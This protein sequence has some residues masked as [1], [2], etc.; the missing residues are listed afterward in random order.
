MRAAPDC[1]PPLTVRH[2]SQPRSSTTPPPQQQDTVHRELLPCTGKG[3]IAGAGQLRIATR[4]AA[5]R[6]RAPPQPKASSSGAHQGLVGIL[7]LWY[8]N[9]VCCTLPCVAETLTARDS[10]AVFDQANVR[11]QHPHQSPRVS[12]SPPRYCPNQQPDHIRFEI[13]TASLCGQIKAPAR[14]CHDI[15]SAAPLLLRSSKHGGIRG[16]AHLRGQGYL[17]ICGVQSSPFQFARPSQRPGAVQS[18]V[19]SLTVSSTTSSGG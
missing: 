5:G 8:I 6:A 10:R 19:Y 15:T 3:A 16:L 9:D 2:E 12:G 13:S 18:A 17:H 4:Q 1:R 11:R 7:C 14:R